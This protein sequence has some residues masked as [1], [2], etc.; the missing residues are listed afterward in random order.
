MPARDINLEAVARALGDTVERHVDVKALRNGESA[1]EPDIADA[2][3]AE[4]LRGF[5]LPEVLETSFVR[6]RL[7]ERFG[8]LR[9]AYGRGV[10]FAQKTLRD[11]LGGQAFVAEPGG[12]QE[13]AKNVGDQAWHRPIIFAASDPQHDVAAKLVRA[14]L[15]RGTRTAKVIA[16]LCDASASFLDPKLRDRVTMLGDDVLP[17]KNLEEA[18]LLAT[19]GDAIIDRLLRCKRP[20]TTA[21][22]CARTLRL[23]STKKA[24]DALRVYWDTE[25][26]GIAEELAQLLDL[27]SIPYLQRQVRKAQES[28]SGPNLPDSVAQGVHDIKLLSE[29]KG[30]QLLT[31][32]STQIADIKPLRD[33][34]DLQ[35]LYLNNID[36]ADIEL[37]R[38]LSRLQ[39]LGL[40]NTKIADTS[41][42]DH[43][44]GLTISR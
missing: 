37:L 13:M 44:E 34:R 8:L 40:S 2:L 12:V 22:A 26:Q 32:D 21:H 14:L 24:K 27:S 20:K 18:A 1:L 5:R 36:V 4:K 7:A 17:P 29:L 15:K 6:K 9:E 16:L 30:L 42:L 10:D 38:E 11:F 43:I 31:L 35:Y 19:L 28:A 23:I 39:F 33:L 41:V 25:Q 3:I